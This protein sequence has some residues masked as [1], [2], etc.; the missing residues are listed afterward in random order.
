MNCNFPEHSVK[1]NRRQLYSGTFGTPNNTFRQNPHI[2]QKSTN[3]A[4]K[5][6]IL[7][8][9]AIYCEM[10]N[11]TKMHFWGVNPPI[12]GKRAPRNHWDSLGD[13][14]VFT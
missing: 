5:E 2:A 11:F 12:G 7:A 9:N 13:I 8:R 4:K 1:I 6:R 14:D 10:V 3:F